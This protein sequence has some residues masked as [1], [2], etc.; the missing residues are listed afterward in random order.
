MTVLAACESRT[1]L[2]GR[3]LTDFAGLEK[4]VPEW[5][6]LLRGSPARGPMLSPAWMLSWWRVFGG[7][8][9]RR[10]AVAAFSE[11]GRLVG[12]VPLTAWRHWHR[13]GI[14]FR[15][16]GPLGTGEAE[17]DAVC[18]DYL[19]PIAAAGTEAAVAAGLAD[20][21]A[22][23]TLGPWGE[24]VW[25]RMDGDSAMLSLLTGALGR[26]GFEVA[27]TPAGDAPYIPLPPTWDAYL[28]SLSSSRRYYVNRSLRDFDRW[29]GSSV[30]LRRA[31]SRAEVEEGLRVRVALHGRRWQAAGQAGA[32]ASQRF[33][34]F[35]EALAPVLLEE[36]VLD[37]LWLCARGEPVAVLFNL[38]R[39]G[40]VYFY[41]SGRK[42]DVPKG[43]RP[44]VVLHA[45]AIRQAITAGRREYDFLAGRERYKT[46]LALRS[47]PLV[48]LR[49]A[50]FSLRERAR[51]LT[52]SATGCARGWLGARRRGPHPDD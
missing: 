48:D 23:G 36:G 16:L 26:A 40:K 38:V 3:V 13:P 21:L 31:T 15:R 30:E 45:H 35:H 6:E 46:Q 8:G 7:L 5:Q 51:R 9:G 19:C 37:L 10:L 28:A 32:F 43:V 49:V 22:A 39:D 29:A 42:V 44:G 34:A 17:A 24:M 47:R 11:G 14:P 50:R 2:D 52:E 4:I 41:Q 12:L 20:M 1:G 18:P 25:P 27:V 33:R